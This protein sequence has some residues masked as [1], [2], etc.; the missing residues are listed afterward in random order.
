MLLVVVAQVSYNKHKD[1]NL[2]SQ[3]AD[4]T[5]GASASVE[6]PTQV[7]RELLKY[8]LY[9]MHM[10]LAYQITHGEDCSLGVY[11]LEHAVMHPPSSSS[12]SPA[13]PCKTITKYLIE[14][15]QWVHV[16]HV[17]ANLWPLYTHNSVISCLRTYCVTEYRMCVDFLSCSEYACVASSDQGNKCIVVSNSYSSTTFVRTSDPVRYGTIGYATSDPRSTGA[18]VLR[19]PWVIVRNHMNVP[20]R[21]GC[22][23]GS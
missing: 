20:R 6:G 18:T 8:A 5:A 7:L 2:L 19:F 21:I 17:R 12:C 3:Q 4:K 9:N 22:Y 11:F 23:K 10:F 16:V 15:K 13:P 1:V 14:N